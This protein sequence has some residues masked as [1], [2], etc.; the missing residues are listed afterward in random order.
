ELA[1]HHGT[2][3]IDLRDVSIP[4][5]AV[6]ITAE[7]IARE[8]RIMPLSIDGNLVR[9][10]TSDPSDYTTLQ[11][12]TFILN[13]DLE[14]VLAD[15]DQI[16]AAIDAYH[17]AP[18][19][20]AVPGV[21]SEMHRMFEE[22]I[23]PR[24]VALGIG[25]GVMVQRKINTFGTGESHVEEKVADLTRRDH[26]PEVGITAS[27]ATISLRIFARAPTVEAAK[28][29]YEPVEKIIRERLGSL[30]Y[31]VDDDELQDA[32]MRLLAEKNK[33]VATA[34]SITAGLVAH[35]LAHVPG[36]SKWLRGGIVCYDSRVKIDQ[37]DVPEALIREHSAVSAQVAERLAASVRV[38]LAA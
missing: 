20:I 11:K 36:A 12:L 24:L 3:L 1:E 25:G 4:S 26:V 17:G 27:D 9:I 28:A 22:Q 37:L 13:K 35:R 23:R 14:I 8:N 29:Q 32:V 19:V 34:E 33:S 6:A 38:K 7:E 18:I 5:A 21:P 2:S 15:E 10:A 30:V 31:G 16:L